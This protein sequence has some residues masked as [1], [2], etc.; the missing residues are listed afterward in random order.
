MGNIDVFTIYFYYTLHLEIFVPNMLEMNNLVHSKQSEQ[1]CI[2]T[3]YS[4]YIY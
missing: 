4:L 2:Q 1:S 3:Q